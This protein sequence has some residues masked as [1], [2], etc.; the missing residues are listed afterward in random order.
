MSDLEELWIENSYLI[1]FFNIILNNMYN[2][3]VVKKTS[4]FFLLNIIFLIFFFSILN[5]NLVI[6]VNT[7]IDIVATHYPDNYKKEFELLYVNL[8]YK[9]N[10]RFFLK[11]LVNKDNIIISINKLF[12]SA[13]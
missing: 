10:L 5:S 6:K 12:E 8:N 2:I 7:I 1:L 11:T 13:A 3:F 4:I 9:L